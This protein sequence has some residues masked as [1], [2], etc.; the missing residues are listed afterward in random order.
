MAGRKGWYDEKKIWEL[1]DLSLTYLK[2]VLVNNT[3]KFTDAQ[4][5]DVAKHVTGRFGPRE[6][7]V[8]IDNK[9]QIFQDLNIEDMPTPKIVQEINSRLNLKNAI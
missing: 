4:M 5:L 2:S 3:G 6:P 9:T 8:S 7:L 1:Y